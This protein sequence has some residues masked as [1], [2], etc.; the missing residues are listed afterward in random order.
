[1]ACDAEEGDEEKALERSDLALLDEENV[2]WERVWSRDVAGDALP[3]SL[4]ELR[5]VYYSSGSHRT[6]IHF[7]LRQAEVH[8]ILTLTDNAPQGL[9]QALLSSFAHATQVG[10]C[11]FVLQTNSYKPKLGLFVS[12]TP[13]V[14]GRPHTL[15]FNGSVKSSGAV[16]LALSGSPRPVAHT[17]FPG[18]RA[19]TAPLKVTQYV[20]TFLIDQPPP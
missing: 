3:A 7:R 19:I 13:F 15:I 11:R 8:T 12:S 16:G 9:N 2:D 6:V 4:R 17:A 5:C 1:V 20:P 14:T 18:L 10:T